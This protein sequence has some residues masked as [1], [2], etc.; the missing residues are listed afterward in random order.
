VNMEYPVASGNAFRLNLQMLIDAME[1]LGW[2]YIVHRSGET[3]GLSRCLL[4][5]GQS[6]L[7]K[8]VL[9]I[10]PEEFQN[11]F[12]AD[13]FSYVTTS[14][15]RGEAP[16]IRC[17]ECTFPELVNDVMAAFSYYSDFERALCNTISGGG[18]LSELCCVASRFLRNPIYVHD[19]VFCV[20]GQSSNVDGSI[21][22]EYSEKTKNPHIPLWL[23]NELKFDET[24]KN[25]LQK[26]EAGIWGNDH[27][28]SNVR[29]L[30]VNLWEGEEYLGRVLINEIE[31]SIRPGQFRTAEFFA[32]YVI[33]WMKNL[34]LSNQQINYSFEQ[35]FNDLLSKGEADERDLK[36]ILGILDWKYEDRYICLKFQNQDAG[37]TV[38]SDLAVN[39]RLSSAF[40]GYYSFRH[41]QKL[42]V[43]I[44]L[45][46]AGIDLG[47][48]RLRL[49]PIIRDSCLYAGISNPVEGIQSLYYG[50][51]QA[52]ISLD[53]ITCIDSSDWMVFFSSC[54]LNYI[55]E[56]S[57]V[58]LPAQM[59]V[60]PVIL[61][62]IEHDRIQGTQYYDTLRI[63]LLCERN[64]PATAAALIIHRTTLT[65][66][67]GKILEHTR[68]N[69]DDPNL[70]L[71]LLISFQLLEQGIAYTFRHS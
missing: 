18:S 64:I 28:Y 9:Y 20:I 15:L 66:R 6:T 48:L 68:L 44:N 43:I 61:D 1:D 24:Y 54:A 30:Y 55:R 16:H 35:T 49:A 51:V 60:H 12:P 23:I 40:K 47:D 42:C 56:S 71:Y 27:D 67:L 38:R 11:G 10:V 25:T 36:T 17:A 8:E 22:F 13:Y 59:V 57:C 52:D 5:Y 29:S 46:V 21:E 32:G 3:P 7:S 37:D 65:Y 14:S 2:K 41:Q 26:K 53:Y 69:L 62:L 45:T 70:R 63:Y 50:F 39:T 4:Y 33:L 19:N 31:S 34:A 58:K